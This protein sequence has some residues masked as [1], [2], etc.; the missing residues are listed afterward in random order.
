M[1]LGALAYYGAYLVRY[2]GTPPDEQLAIFTRTLP[3]V[4]ALQMLAFLVWGVYRGLWHYLG[5]HDLVVIAKA[6]FTCTLANSLL[7]LTMYGFQGPSRAVLALNA[8]LLLCAVSASRLS[9][10]LLQVLLVGR[11]QVRPDATPVFIY[12]AGSGGELL[13]RELLSNSERQYV[14]VGFIDDDSRKIG[15]RLHGYRIF[16]SQQLLD[17]LQTHGVQDVL[18]LSAKVPESRLDALR[19]IGVCLKKMSIR[20]E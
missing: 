20:I 16:D 9:F 1:V 15:K 7:V 5:V 13:L 18:I 4:L 3:P 14:P 11:A 2:D 19:D 6:V 17:L 8:L 12:G 10:R